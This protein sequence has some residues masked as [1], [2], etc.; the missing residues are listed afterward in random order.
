MIHHEHRVRD[1]A[2]AKAFAL[3]SLE[4]GTPRGWHD[5]VRH[6]WQARAEDEHLQR[7]SLLD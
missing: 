4:H 2:A 3:R 5:A 6:Q 1:L 7:G